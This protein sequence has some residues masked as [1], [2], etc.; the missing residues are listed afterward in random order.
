METKIRF[1]PPDL[2]AYAN[3]FAKGHAHWGEKKINFRGTRIVKFNAT[4]A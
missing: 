2:C 4:S 3:F 1:Q